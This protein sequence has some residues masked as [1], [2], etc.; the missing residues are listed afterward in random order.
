M[1]E[2]VIIVEVDE[3]QH[4]DYDCSCENKRTM[5]LS[6]DIGH[7]PL[8]FVRFNPDDYMNNE[9][10]ITSCWRTNKSGIC[11]VQKSKTKEWNER[12]IAL[13]Q[14]IEYWTNNNT[15]KTV[16]IVQL[17]YNCDNS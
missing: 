12:L 8:V 4:T 16:E 14:Q 2:Q 17:F 5:E 1:G 9:K 6:K 7:R 13:K 3:N 10:K 11:V 15:D